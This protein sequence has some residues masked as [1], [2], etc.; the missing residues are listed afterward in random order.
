MLQA[1]PLALT[2]RLSCFKLHEAKAF[3]FSS[4]KHFVDKTVHEVSRSP[5]TLC[6]TA[7]LVH[8]NQKAVCFYRLLILVHRLAI[9]AEAR[10]ETV[11]K[12]VFNANPWFEP[13]CSFASKRAC[14][15]SFQ[16]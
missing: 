4:E 12:V 10:S 7:K 13:K 16:A 15:S 3:L 11:S 14:N 5:R 2:C 1:A 9:L 6:S 8:T